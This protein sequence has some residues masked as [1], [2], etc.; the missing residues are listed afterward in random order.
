MHIVGS[1]PL[2]NTVI[3]NKDASDNATVVTT[4]RKAEGKDSKDK[5]AAVGKK[6]A[7]NLYTI[8]PRYTNSHIFQLLWNSLKTQSM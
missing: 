3:E 5:D 2:T 8:I 7:L 6:I 4:Q 1:E